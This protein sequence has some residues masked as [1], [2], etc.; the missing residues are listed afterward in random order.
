MLRFVFPRARFC[1]F[2][3]KKN[4]DEE[5]VGLL[6]M[7][8]E[9]GPGG[10]PEECSFRRTFYISIKQRLAPRYNF[11]HLPGISRCSSSSSNR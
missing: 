6:L 10:A 9:V 3:L 8:W 5:L 4:I 1:F 11:P 2:A 7:V